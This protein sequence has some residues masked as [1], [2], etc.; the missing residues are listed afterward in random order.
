MIPNY[1]GLITAASAFLGI[2][3]GHVA[4]RKIEYIS[5]TIWL[6]SLVA[7]LLGLTMEVGALV[8]DNL[9]LSA[10]LGIIGITF[11]W[12]S[13]EFFRQH[14][15]IKKGHAPANPANPRHARLLAKSNQATT[16]EWLDR[17]PIG[18]QLSPEELDS[19]PGSRI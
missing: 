11:L 9:N 6:P 1:I 19:I 7:L 16:I 10:A 14:Q 3:F 17:N 13:I 8:A 2:W 15:R 18:R 12:D 5:P 4:V